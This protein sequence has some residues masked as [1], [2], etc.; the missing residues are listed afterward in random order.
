MPAL[1]TRISTRPWRLRIACAER[2]TSFWSETSS[3]IAS[4]LPAALICFSLASSV[5]RLRPEMITWAPA[6]A[7]S[8]PPASPMP[9]PPPVIH[10]TLPSSILLCAE[11]ILSLLVR[12]LGPAPLGEHLHP[13]LHGRAFE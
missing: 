7:S 11:Q 8:I 6:R 5:S 10:A 1:F 4:P 9:D 3:E 2:D 12:H 13:A